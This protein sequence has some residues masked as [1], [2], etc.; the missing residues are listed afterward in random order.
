MFFCAISATASYTEASGPM[1]CTAWSPFSLRISATVF[2]A[3][4]SEQDVSLHEN[5]G[6][7]RSASPS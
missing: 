1:L 3:C 7:A 4:V 2:I 6:W 5:T